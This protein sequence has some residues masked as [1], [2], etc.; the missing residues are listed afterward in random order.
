MPPSL[1]LDAERLER[2]EEHAEDAGALVARRPVDAAAVVDRQPVAELGRHLLE[3][4]RMPG[5]QARTPSRA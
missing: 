2:V 1:P 3:L 5:H 4:H